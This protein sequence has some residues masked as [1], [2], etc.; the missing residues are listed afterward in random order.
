MTAVRAVLA[1]GRAGALSAYS[2]GMRQALYLRYGAATGARNAAN[3]S[4]D[5]PTP[6]IRISSTP[7]DDGLWSHA[8]FCLAPAGDG[9]GVRVA[10]SAALNC[11]PLIAQPYTMQGFEDVLPYEAFSRRLAFAEIEGLPALLRRY[12]HAD[13]VRMRTAL[14]AARRAFAWDDAGLA[15]DYTLLSLCHRAVELRG[16]LRAGPH[17]SC[18]QLAAR[19][20]MASPQRRLPA[21]FPPSLKEAT[22][23]LVRRRRCASE[24]REPTANALHAALRCPPPERAAEDDELLPFQIFSR[25]HVAEALRIREATACAQ[26]IQ[27]LLHLP[28]LPA[29]EVVSW[30]GWAKGCFYNSMST[31][32]GDTT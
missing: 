2:L 10:K 16:T 31:P 8:R 11:V 15:Y 5:P 7:L 20:P 28:T 6:G 19:L 32:R 29:V 1:G 3:A 27:T 21:W 4:D 13:I 25:G 23:E 26:G 22:E 9:W 24:A 30:Q 12:S 17:A 18:D 14:E